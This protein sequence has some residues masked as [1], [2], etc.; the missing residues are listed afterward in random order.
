MADILHSGKLECYELSHFDITKDNFRAMIEGIAPG[1]YIKLSCNG[2]VL[3][4]NTPMEQRTNYG[5]VC[6]SFGD[7]LIGGLGIG[8][9]L[10]AIQDKPEIKSITVIE[11]SSDLI[12]LVLPQLELNQKVTVINAD[13]FDWKPPKWRKY[14]CIYMDILGYINSDVYKEMVKLKRK[15]SHYLKPKDESPCRFNMCWAEY[16]AKN[17]R[18]LL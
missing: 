14:D 18:R 3:M 1:R 2:E 8:M 11:K 17:N 16:E 7:V 4:S 15:Y 9:I 6:R 12:K 10:V 13:V 5:F